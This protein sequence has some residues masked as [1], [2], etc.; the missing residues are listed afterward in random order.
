M[1]GGTVGFAFV[2][3]MVALLNP[4]GFPLLAVYL[5]SF[6]SGERRT[7]AARIYAGLRAGLALTIGFVAVFAAAG[8]LAGSLHA[9]V[10]TL[11][12]WLMVAV[13]VA[14]VALGVLT[15]SARV[16]PVHAAVPFRSGP[17]FLPMTGF[18][19]AYA[20][21]SLSCSLPIFVAAV[22]SGLASG[23]GVVTA[24]V[25]VGYGLGMGLFATV[26]ALIASFA[27]AVTF[28]RLRRV[29]AVL[30]RAAGAVCIVIGLYL[31]AYWVGQAGG[32]QVVGQATLVLDTVQEAIVAAIEDAWLPIGAALAAIVIVALVVAARRTRPAARVAASADQGPRGGGGR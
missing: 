22:G 2:L 3:G 21:G 14:I 27:G 18:G 15:L 30:P 7:W 26:V 29:A 4:C 11:A 23:S 6:V 31:I 25:V 13:A 24:A 20:V 17:G 8:L 1:T 32:P 5:A 28:G 16:I 10:T 12:P 19:I 9:V